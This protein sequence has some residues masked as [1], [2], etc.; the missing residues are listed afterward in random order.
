M[1]AVII[2][3]ERGGL[4]EEAIRDEEEERKRKEQNDGR[5]TGKGEKRMVRNRN[6]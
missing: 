2:T 1:I 6:G 3:T 5:G 4:E